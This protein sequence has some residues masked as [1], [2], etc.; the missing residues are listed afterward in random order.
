MQ[1][2]PADLPPAHAPDEQDIGQVV[3]TQAAK[4]PLVPPVS[5]AS[6]NFKPPARR[7]RAPASSD[8]PHL[9]Q[10]RSLEERRKYC[11]RL[12]AVPVL[13]DIRAINDRRRKN[14]RKSDLTTAIDEIV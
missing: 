14:Q 7:Q 9:F 3:R 5:P 6:F 1:Y 11:R 10:E 12:H 13:Y 2:V 4:D 8:E